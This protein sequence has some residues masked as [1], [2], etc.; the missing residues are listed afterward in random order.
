MPSPEFMA[1]LA[2][3]PKDIAVP[4]DTYED[5][6]RKFGPAHGH[7]PGP[8]I[9][10][11]PA[12][13]GGVSGV[14]VAK[15]GE[16]ASERVI[17][18]VHGG[19]FVSCPAPTYAFYAAW[20]VRATGARAFVVDYRLAPEHR[21]PAALHDCAAAWRGLVAAGVEPERAAFFGD[22][23]GGGIAIATLLR[24]RDLDAPLPACAALHC[25]WFDLEVSGDSALNPVGDDPFVNAEWI[26]Q[27]GRDYLGPAGNARDPFA[28]PIHARLSGLPPL[29]LQTGQLDTL[30]DDAVRLAARAGRDGSS[31]TLEIWPG[32]IHGFLGMHGAIPEAS[33]AVR[34][35]AEFI[36][37]HT[38]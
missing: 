5:V 38:K 12:R 16:R 23:C 14:W 13:V 36:A 26:R 30:R 28:S 7:D 24:L 35:V 29:L 27:R 32:M 11:E 22:S 33:W 31:V 34:H 17:F 19:A 3:F 4:G 10:V 9:S 25:G 15:K 6:R 20:L 1:A 2:H 8:D 21:H 18:F 37:H